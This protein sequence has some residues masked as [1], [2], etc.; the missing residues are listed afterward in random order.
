M[1]FPWQTTVYSLSFSVLLGSVVVSAAH[2][3]LIL[4]RAKDLEGGSGSAPNNHF[5]R[6]LPP[7]TGIDVL[8][9]ANHHNRDPGPR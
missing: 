5:R 9:G 6:R 2:S 1:A 8:D 7:S 3:L 4:G